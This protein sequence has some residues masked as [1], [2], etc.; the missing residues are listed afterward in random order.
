MS[1]KNI[2]VIGGG[3]HAKSV[4]SVIKKSGQFK[5]VGYTDVQ[6]QGEIL[7]VA[8]IGTD[9]DR[10]A[11]YNQYHCCAVLGIGSTKISDQRCK[12]IKKFTASGFTFPVIISPTAIVNED[13]EIG[14]ATVI[15]DGV[16]VNAG[17]RVGQ[18]CILNTGSIIDHD[19]TIGDFVHIAPGVILSGGVQIGDHCLLGTGAKVIQCRSIGSD[20]LIGAGAVVVED[21]K[22]SGTYVGVPARGKKEQS[23]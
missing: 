11:I 3:G 15:L 16:I 21:I 17:T 23:V 19:C 9:E 1:V 18:G 10:V 2:L 7:G 8:W 20:C 4:I 5:I 13:V 14:E 22:R 6:D 12:I